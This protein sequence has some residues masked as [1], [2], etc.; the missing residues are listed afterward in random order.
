[1]A[2]GDCY[3]QDRQAAVERGIVFPASHRQLSPTANFF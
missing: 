1:M 2:A 3:E